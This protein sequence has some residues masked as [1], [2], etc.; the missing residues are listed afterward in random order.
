MY[1]SVQEYDRCEHLALE[2]TPNRVA[3]AFQPVA[4][5]HVGYPTRIHSEQ[6]LLK[7]VDVMHELEFATNCRQL[8][9]L[10][11]NEFELVKR[12]TCQVAAFT[13]ERF[14]TTVIA[15][16]SI[17]RSLN[18]L[19]HIRHV[20]GEARPRVFEAGPGCGYLGALLMLE[21]YPYAAMDVTQAFYLYQS[22]F[23]THL[24]SG[25]LKERVGQSS[26]TF[27]KA[28]A[29][30]KG[31][32][33]LHV[34][35][36]DFANAAP[37]D[38]GS[39]DLLVCNRALCEMHPD[40]LRFFLKTGR[41]ALD[42]EGGTKCLLFDG[43]GADVRNK[44]I[45]T[46]QIL[47]EY[48][49]RPVYSSDRCNVYLPKGKNPFAAVR[50]LDEREILDGACNDPFLV[51][52]RLVDLVK[53]NPI[54]VAILRGEEAIR[55][56]AHVQ[57]TELEKF[58]LSEWGKD[59]LLTPDEAF[60]CFTRLPDLPCPF[61]AHRALVIFGAG[62]M[63]KSVRTAL[64]RLGVVPFGFTDNDPRKWGQRLDG[65]AIL[66]P[67]SLP[68]QAFLIIGVRAGADGIAAQLEAKGL[69]EGVDFIFA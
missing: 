68:K 66:P 28:M 15:R 48:G 60:W 53:D 4:F 42:P 59:C 61:P 9:A 63:G 58:Y 50:L 17:L 54:K 69:T 29:C 55:H 7:Y 31:D 37:G 6:E 38:M 35:W 14:G 33:P 64:N 49:F 3:E 67:E 32:R 1:L 62:A 23:W 65:L 19:R 47:H 34:P 5:D 30:I 51:V 36:W 22:Q 10:T 57:T 41:Q 24:T 56:S 39:F 20:Y 13:Q 40:S 21:G 27:E 8:G 45:D 26:E 25:K 12:L 18:V 2:G 16:S 52:E 43:W 46:V 11:D 44:V